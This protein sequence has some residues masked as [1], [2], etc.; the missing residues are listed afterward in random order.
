MTGA[1]GGCC[2]QLFTIFLKFFLKFREQTIFKKALLNALIQW[3][4]FFVGF[5]LYLFYCFSFIIYII[6][7]FEKNYP[8]VLLPQL[9]K[10]ASKEKKENI[11]PTLSL[12]H[13]KQETSN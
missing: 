2:K 8:N 10:D 13:P 5:L 6:L 1:N 4:F 9:K 3:L 7:F 11:D 12:P